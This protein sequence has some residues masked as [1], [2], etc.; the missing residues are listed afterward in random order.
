MRP[1]PTVVE[2]RQYTVKPGRRDDLIDLF[3]RHFIGAQEAVGAHV[4]GHFRDL[5]EPDRF[6]W[7]RGFRNMPTRKTALEAFYGSPTWL[8]HRDAANEIILDSDNVYLLEP[9]AGCALD[10]GWSNPGGLVTAT[11]WPIARPASRETLSLFDVEVAPML[12]EAGASLASLLVTAAAENNFP[13][14]PV[15]EGEHVIVLI[16]R[17]IDELAIARSSYALKRTQQWAGWERLLDQ[18]LSGKPQKLLLAP[19]PRCVPT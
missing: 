16:A 18:Q 11:I 5:D 9:A 2:L 4:L 17:F 12:G 19:A 14:L 10:S 15:R 6:V 8:H 3:T 1:G 13:R 7:M